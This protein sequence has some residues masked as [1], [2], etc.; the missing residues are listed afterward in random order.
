MFDN[1]CAP[2]GK[3]KR[4]NTCKLT[5]TGAAEVTPKFGGVTAR[6]VEGVHWWEGFRWLAVVLPFSDNVMG[7]SGKQ[8]GFVV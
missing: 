5:S 1:S 2:R 4:L 7:W 3:T 6:A 8:R